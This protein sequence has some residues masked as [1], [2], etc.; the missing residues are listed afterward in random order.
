MIR[1]VVAVIALLASL[2]SDGQGQVVVN[3][4]MANEP[5]AFRNLEWIE[6]ISTSAVPVNLT[7]FVL[8]TDGDTVLFSEGLT[9]TPG[10]FLILCRCLTAADGSASFEGYWGDS[11]GVWGDCDEEI[12]IGAPLEADFGL[13]NSGG[14]VRLWDAYAEISRFDWNESGAD[15]VSWERHEPSGDV[16]GPCEDISGSTPGR[17]NSTTPVE[18]DLAIVAVDCS[19]E[20]RQTYI[21]ITVKNQGML[22]STMADL[23]LTGSPGMISET[24]N[25]LDPGADIVVVFIMNLDELWTSFVVSLPDDDRP[26]NNRL[27]V[28]VPGRYYPPLVITEFLPNPKDGLGS[29]WVELY[30]RSD[31]DWNL[32]S[33]QIGDARQCY[34]LTDAGVLR[35]GERIVV[36]QDVTAMLSYYLLDEAAVVE[37]TAWSRLN[38]DVDTVRLIDPYGLVADACPYD[39]VFDNNHSWCRGETD[40]YFDV[41]GRSEQAGGS[42]G[43]SN[44]VVFSETGGSVAMEVLPNIFSPDGDGVDDSCLIR[45][46]APDLTEFELRIFDR[47]GREVC[48]LKDGVYRS[49]EYYW[50]GCDDAGKRVA[51][52][53]YLI[54]F[55]IG[56]GDARKAA[57]VVA[58]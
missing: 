56:G 50:N 41:W 49:N 17:I 27:Q 43:E 26:D 32:D 45:L 19:V 46:N 16:I 47:A 15:G 51:V 38:D 48:D 13:T 53:M 14:S 37:P 7:E 2:I 57:V 5:G 10:E 29:E 34:P 42:P 31:Q 11:S 20:N 25:P 12:T 3:E 35:P 9:I 28:I 58:R 54:C 18:R 1:L 55:E 6:L 36:A 22:G 21:R 39:E 44:D 33:W 24:V 40:E 8:Y 30:N 52:G 23:I 4:V